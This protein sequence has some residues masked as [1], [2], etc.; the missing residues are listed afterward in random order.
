MEGIIMPYVVYKSIPWVDYD[1][2]LRKPKRMKYI[3]SVAGNL[4]GSCSGTFFFF[5]F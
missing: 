5:F 3:I 2:V 4:G 1:H